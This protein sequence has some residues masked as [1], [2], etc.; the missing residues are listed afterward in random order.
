MLPRLQFEQDKLLYHPSTQSWYSPISCIWAEDNIQLPGKVSI[1]TAYKGKKSFFTKVLGVPKPTLG[2][3]ILA[4]RSKTL[5]NP[6]KE[7]VMLEMLNICAYNPKPEA[8]EELCDC[9]CL[10]ITLADGV[11]DWVDRSAMFSIVDRREYDELFRG[12]L[13]VLAFSLEEV[14]PLE[15]FLHGLGLADRYMSQAVQE[16]TKTPDGLMHRRL[17]DDLRNKAYAI[18]R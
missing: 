10:P 7:E 3:H 6:K 14:H 8:L 16:E 9:K 5:A 13:K 2:D 17:T 18:C 15:S 1:A 11:T 4:L 12:K